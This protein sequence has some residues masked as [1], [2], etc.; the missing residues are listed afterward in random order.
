MRTKDFS[1][2]NWLFSQACP[3]F[4]LALSWLLAAAERAR[5]GASQEIARLLVRPLPRRRPAPSS[6]Y[7]CWLFNK[8][9]QTEDVCS[10]NWLFSQA[11]PRFILA[12]SWWFAALTSGGWQPRSALARAHHKKTHGSSARS[13][14][15]TPRPSIDAPSATS[16]TRPISQVLLPLFHSRYRSKKVLEPEAE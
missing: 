8:T 7:F 14:H 3:R 4:I 9:M 11:C 1:S 12:L 13:S 16:H 6:P 10:Q 5:A 2:Q 15:A